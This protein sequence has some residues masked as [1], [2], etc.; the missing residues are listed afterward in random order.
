MIYYEKIGAVIRKSTPLQK[1][2]RFTE[3]QVEKF[4]TASLVVLGIVGVAGAIALSAM[5]PNIF[6][7]IGKLFLQKYPQRKF[8]KKEKDLKIAQTFYYLKRSGQIKM[9][10][11]GRDFL[12]SLTKLGRHRFQRLQFEN[13]Q[14]PQPKTWSGKW[15]AVAADIPTK[16][17][18][19]ADLFREKLRDL[20]LYGLQRTLWFFPYDP[21]E[22]IEFI[23]DHYGIGRFVT[24]ME[25]S[26]LDQQDEKLMLAFFRKEKITS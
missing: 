12:V 23:A 4:K 3:E 17:K 8:S 2:P 14:I 10:L 11:E 24:V 6:I 25:V 7:A 21:R 16:Y 15:W 5:A 18:R 20:K 1:L 13:L 26:R 9:K 19:G 22:E